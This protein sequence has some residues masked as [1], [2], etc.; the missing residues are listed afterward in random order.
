M[1]N[2]EL[3]MIKNGKIAV[4]NKHE[5]VQKDHQFDPCH[6]VSTGETNFYRMQQGLAPI[7]FDD[8]PINLH[9]MK[10]QKDGL[11]VETTSTDHKKH[12]ELLHRYTNTSEIDR[13]SFN[14]FRKTYWKVRFAGLPKKVCNISDRF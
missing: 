11:L 3:D 9:H 14:E 7:G 5:V 12:H 10:Q 1:T 6:K 8:Q 13:D 2:L 4:I